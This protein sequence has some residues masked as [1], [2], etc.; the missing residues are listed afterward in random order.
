MFRNDANRI[1]YIIIFIILF[2]G[3]FC[4]YDLNRML[5]IKSQIIGYFQHTTTSIKINDF[6]YDINQ[7]LFTNSGTENEYFAEVKMNETVTGFDK[8]K[9]YTLL[10]NN[11]QAT[12]VNGNFGYVNVDFM[13]KFYS[14]NETLLLTDTLNIKIN[15]YTDST[16]IVFITQN[17]EQAVKLWTSFIQ[18][19]G[20]N[21]KIIEDNFNSKIEADNIP[22]YTLTLYNGDEVLDVIT[23]NGLNPVTLPTTIDGFAIISWKDV[24]GYEY[25]QDTLPNKDIE[26]Y[27]VVSQTRV[28]FTFNQDALTRC[29]SKLS[30]SNCKYS[31]RYLLSSFT[32]SED[33]LNLFYDSLFSN[34][35]SGYTVTLKITDFYDNEYY[36][37][38]NNTGG[39]TT[40]SLSDGAK[41]FYY[42]G[43][44]IN[45][46]NPFINI[47]FNLE[48]KYDSLTQSYIFTPFIDLEVGKEDEDVDEKYKTLEENAEQTKMNFSVVVE[49][50]KIT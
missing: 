22:E 25:T 31:P 43:T 45:Q 38:S 14:T 3:T 15:F 49:I 44:K 28:Q 29:I 33:V 37:N 27:A 7:L 2:F 19:N 9:N 20:L 21:L 36:F 30:N 46:E 26:L 10:V 39:L 13:N 32:C 6:E 11:T 41:M 8:S 12:R 23:F 35:K 40:S 34:P 48:R 16:K 42:Y 1:G 18:K 4:I 50:S 47:E 24:D 17:G 5:N